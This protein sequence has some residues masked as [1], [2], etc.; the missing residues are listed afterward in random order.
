MVASLDQNI[1]VNLY[2]CYNSEHEVVFVDRVEEEI[3]E[4]VG[5]AL[6]DLLSVLELLEQSETNR[7]NLVRV[8]FDVEPFLVD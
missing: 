5:H 7:Q 2:F 3:L 8:T 1:A 6:H 4:L